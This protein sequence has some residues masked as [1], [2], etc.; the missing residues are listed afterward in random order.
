MASRVAAQTSL[1]H[2]VVVTDPRTDPTEDDAAAVCALVALNLHKPFARSIT[3]LVTG[4]QGSLEVRYKGIKFLEAFGV[5]IHLAPASNYA[6]RPWAPYGDPAAAQALYNAHGSMEK[7]AE[8]QR[9]HIVDRIPDDTTALIVIGQV[10]GDF[11]DNLVAARSRL[12][13]LK[14]L[15]MQGPGFN[16]MANKPKDVGASIASFIAVY[17]ASVYWSDNRANL[18]IS[19]QDN[20]ERFQALSKLNPEIQETKAKMIVSFWATSGATR[21]FEGQMGDMKGYNYKSHTADLLGRLTQSTAIQELNAKVSNAADSAAVLQLLKDAWKETDPSKSLYQHFNYYPQDRAMVVNY[22]QAA[23]SSQGS[24]SYDELN[25][26][27]FA[28]RHQGASSTLTALGIHVAP[29]TPATAPGFLGGGGWRGSYI[30]M[31]APTTS[32]GSD[33]KDKCHKF[34]RFTAKLINRLAR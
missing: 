14:E 13:N 7:S 26:I 12:V 1:E 9:T 23:C 11:F 10:E 5:K 15:S 34:H 18:M 25:A 3:L 8:A 2:I 33:R 19:S 32:D 22:V 27:E 16:V 17:S 24:R 30:S 21:H 28:L 31:P 20:V 29:S 4:A 6:S